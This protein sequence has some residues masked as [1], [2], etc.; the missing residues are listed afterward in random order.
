[1]AAT[2]IGTFSN[3]ETNLHG[4]VNATVGKLF[5]LEKLTSTISVVDDRSRLVSKIIRA[6]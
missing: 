6:F 5:Y 1:M 4:K 2:L 3:L